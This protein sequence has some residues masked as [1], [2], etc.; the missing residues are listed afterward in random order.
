MSFHQI[1]KDLVFSQDTTDETVT[2]YMVWAGFVF[3]VGQFLTSIVLPAP[4]GRYS[5]SAPRYLNCKFLKFC[6]TFCVPFPT[7][8]TL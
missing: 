4:Y 3:T 7:V 6:F 1:L 2:T 8:Y 5:Q